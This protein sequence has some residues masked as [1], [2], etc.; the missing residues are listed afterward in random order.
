MVPLK[1]SFG[2][3]NRQAET[4]PPHSTKGLACFFPR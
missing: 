1:H 2:N 3:N 4:L